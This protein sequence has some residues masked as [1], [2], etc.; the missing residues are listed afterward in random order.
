MPDVKTLTVSE[1][2]IIRTV[3]Q[4]HLMTFKTTPPSVF[5]V[6]A[7]IEAATMMQVSELLLDKVHVGFYF[8]S[9]FKV[10]NKG[11]VLVTYLES[12]KGK[13]KDS[14]VV[15]RHPELVVY[16]I[17]GCGSVAVSTKMNKQLASILDEQ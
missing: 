9:A 8:Y 3:G 16:D 2:G 11:G 6:G 17:A 1:A 10:A 13:A 4:A 15:F 7:R 14:S 12:K 5:E